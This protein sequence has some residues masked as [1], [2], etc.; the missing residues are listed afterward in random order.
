[1][2]AKTGPCV[3]AGLRR[4]EIEIG[5]VGG[6]SGGDQLRV[7]RR[8]RG[9]L[10]DLEIVL[11]AGNGALADIHD[12]AHHEHR[13]LGHVHQLQEHD[14]VTDGEVA[15]QGAPEDQP[16]DAQEDQRHGRATRGIHGM[17]PARLRLRRIHHCA[18]A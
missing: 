2:K 6:V 12:P 13:L 18:V 16:I 5:D 3:S 15:L 4:G 11:G 7:Y 14:H 10:H 8:L 1:M 17:P 9:L